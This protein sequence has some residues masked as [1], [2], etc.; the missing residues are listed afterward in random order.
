MNKSKQKREKYHPLAVNKIAEM[1]GFSAHQ[2]TH[3]LCE[4]AYSG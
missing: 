2:W 3:Q 4:R 1:Y